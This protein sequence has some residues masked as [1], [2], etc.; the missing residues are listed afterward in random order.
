M[1]A[2]MIL[3]LR[4]GGRGS[5]SSTPVTVGKVNTSKDN[6]SGATGNIKKASIL[7]LLGLSASYLI[8]THRHQLFDKQFLQDKTLELLQDANN[9]PLGIFYYSL[10]MAAWETIGLSTIP[11]ETAAGMAFGWKRAIL[12]STAGKLVGAGTA[13]LLGRHVL[14]HWV[15][16]QLET[17]DNFRL[18]EA[19]VANKP[20]VT[21]ILLK[22]SCFPEFVKNFGTSLLKPIPLWGFL[23]ATLVHGGPFTCLWSWLGDDTAARLNY[24]DLPPNRALQSTMVVAMTVGLLLSPAA[25]AWWIRDLRKQHATTTMTTTSSTKT[26]IPAKRSSTRSKKKL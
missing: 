1:S 21:A 3:E 20:L 26:K 25:M 15:R 24:P 5:S 12:A 23:L 16:T 7:T 11:I 4:G 8:Y 18:I 14:H 10:G 17:N 19:S 9:S 6:K 22:Y 2:E 13:F